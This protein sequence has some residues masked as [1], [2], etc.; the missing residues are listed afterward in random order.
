[1]TNSSFNGMD[2]R[3]VAERIIASEERYLTVDP[4]SLSLEEGLCYLIHN[5]ES[6]HPLSCLGYDVKALFDLLYPRLEKRVK[7]GTATPDELYYYSL[8]SGEDE[9]VSPYLDAAVAAGSAKAR[10]LKA[11]NTANSDPDSARRLLVEALSLHSSGKQNLDTASHLVCL[12]LLGELAAD[13]RDSAFYK[14]QTYR[15]AT[16][17]VLE[18]NYYPLA[19][20]RAK[21]LSVRAEAGLEPHCEETL[22]WETVDLLVAELTYGRSGGLALAD[23]LGRKL[24]DGTV[25]QRDVERAKRIYIDAMLGA[26]YDRATLL[27]RVGVPVIDGKECPEVIEYDCRRKI[28]LGKV[29][30]YW[31]AILLGVLAGDRERVEAACDLAIAQGSEAALRNIP[32]AY[33]VLML[34]QRSEV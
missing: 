11:E 20:L 30:Y 27:R 16:E 17:K 12:R 5:F 3:H 31:Q 4:T 25:C 15:L 24:L 13:P 23:T 33:H 2:A 22:F 21:H 6:H 8:L 10:V 26:D 18:G 19:Y 9:F 32:K 29:S 28:S 1:M 34:A 7:N 14:E